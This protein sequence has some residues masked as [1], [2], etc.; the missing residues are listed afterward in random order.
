MW[1]G[2]ELTER[3]E[4]LAG[5]NEALWLLSF[6]SIAE[7]ALLPLPVDAVSLPMMAAARHRIPLIVLVGTLTSV[8]GGL[9]G[10]FIGVYGWELIGTHLVAMFGGE[11]QFAEI[12]A[13]MSADLV[14]GAWWIWLGA[15]TPIPF[16]LVCIGAGVVSYPLWLF[17]AVAVFGRFLRFAFFGIIFWYLGPHAMAFMKKHSAAFGIG[18]I[19][20]IVAGFA[21]TALLF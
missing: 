19:L 11:Q 12:R 21:A 2:K 10:Y 14:N 20:V 16:K 3:A 9:I 18:L 7:S 13:Q 1:S 4:K 17:L 15:V 6:V 5:S 8:I